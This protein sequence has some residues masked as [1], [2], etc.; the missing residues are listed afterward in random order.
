MALGPVLMK[1]RCTAAAVGVFLAL[2]G[3]SVAQAETRPDLV[4]LAGQSLAVPFDQPPGYV[5]CPVAPVVV[6]G[7]PVSLG[8]ATL[9]LSLTRPP[10]AAYSCVLVDNRAAGPVSGTFAGLPEGTIFGPPHG[11]FRITYV[12]GDGNDIWLTRVEVPPTFTLS[13]DVRVYPD[14][15][16]FDDRPITANVYITGD[17]ET[18]LAASGTVTAA[19]DGA[20]IGTFGLVHAAADLPLGSIAVGAHTLTI[21]YSGA[22]YDG[23]ST[24]LADTLTYPF[25]VRHRYDGG[26]GGSV[27]QTPT[28]TPTPVAAPVPAGPAAPGAPS[29]PPAGRPA[30]PAEPAAPSTTRI[31]AALRTIHS[32]V[33]ARRAVTFFQESPAAGTIRWRLLSRSTGA[34]RVLATRTRTVPGGPVSVR[35]ALDA[36]AWRRVAGRPHEH[37]LLET[38]LTTADGRTITVRA[39]LR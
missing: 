10:G 30:T 11:R 1:Q 7:G 12:G 22:T 17:T 26:G 29:T 3:A 24:Y 32:P 35:L 8:G 23:H 21:A 28:T 36:G 33:F 39:R 16:F 6:T 18:S 34:G 27:V 31:R 5:T 25:T 19:V 37:L 2:I 9:S 4:L 15:E 13:F 20:P 14:R 38:R